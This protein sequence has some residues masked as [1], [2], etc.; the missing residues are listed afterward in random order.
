LGRGAALRANITAAGSWWG[1]AIASLRASYAASAGSVGSQHHLDV[2]RDTRTYVAA[3]SNARWT[4]QR[5]LRCATKNL[6][7]T[8]TA[9]ETAPTTD[10]WAA[11][12]EQLRARYKHVRAPVLAALN[13][14]IH[15]QNISIDDAKAQ[16][17]LHGVR[18]TAASVAAART[19]LSR[20]DGP[21]TP[22]ASTTPSAPTGQP[23]RHRAPEKAVDAEAL[24][25]GFVAKLQGQGNAEAERLREAMRKAIA[26]LLS[27][28]G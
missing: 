7:T 22:V 4:Y 5:G 3:P 20:M 25:R 26:V 11:Q 8:M 6:R 19:L 23:R 27:A 9:T 1:R 21:P 10:S 13:I 18:I 12:L 17:A 15:D 14:L 28:V 24:V 2:R 16:A